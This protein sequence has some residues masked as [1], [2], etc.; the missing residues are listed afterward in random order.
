MKA[1]Y[2]MLIYYMRG[3]N[4]GALQPASF[5]TRS[6]A[7]VICSSSNEKLKLIPKLR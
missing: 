7:D 6:Y 2:M 4:T 3:I 5:P 1:T